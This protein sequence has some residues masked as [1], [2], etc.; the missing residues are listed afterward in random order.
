MN[1]WSSIR[2]KSLYTVTQICSFNSYE[3]SILSSLLF[4]NVFQKALMALIWPNFRW[5]DEFQCSCDIST[6]EAMKE[7][8]WNLHINLLKIEPCIKFRLPDFQHCVICAHLHACCPDFCRRL[9]DV[10]WE[11]DAELSSSVNPSSYLR[12][13]LSKEEKARALFHA[14]KENNAILFV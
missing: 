7:S 14:I 6:V 3:I 13:Q 10:Q 12:I 9:K 11:A 8:S 4:I 5:W 1:T 2:A